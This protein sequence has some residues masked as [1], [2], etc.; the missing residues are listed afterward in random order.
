MPLSVYRDH[1]GFKLYIEKLEQLKDSERRNHT[2]KLQL[3]G[4]IIFQV[5]DILKSSS[6][7]KYGL[8]SNNR[9]IHMNNEVDLRETNPYRKIGTVEV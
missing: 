7:N 2:R 9:I 1:T 8:C 6:Y 3:V 5:L 4:M